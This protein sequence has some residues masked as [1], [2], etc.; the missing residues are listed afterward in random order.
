MLSIE[1]PS[2]ED[3]RFYCVSRTIILLTVK[4]FV[5]LVFK[6]FYHRRPANN[7]SQYTF[8]LSL[9]DRLWLTDV[10][11]PACNWLQSLWSF[12]TMGNFFND[13]VMQKLNLCSAWA[14][15]STWVH[16]S[17][18]WCCKK[19]F[20]V[21]SCRC[22]KAHDMTAIHMYMEDNLLMFFTSIKVHSTRFQ[23]SQICI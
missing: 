15:T 10:H 14:D 21:T 9:T 20:T 7:D 4:P 1:N 18:Y 16:S 19:S 2:T 5:L 22:W 17:I 23:F 3:T 12:S 13:G 8:D 6:C 11:Q